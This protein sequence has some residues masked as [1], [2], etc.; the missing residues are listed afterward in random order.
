MK[1]Y[2]KFGDPILYS[3][4]NIHLYLFSGKPIGYIHDNKIYNY[5]GKHLGWL[6]MGWLIDLHGYYSYF[7]ENASGGPI[8]PIKKIT[9]I[10]GIKQ[11]KPIK[12]IREISK[13][14][15]IVQNFWSQF[16]I[17]NN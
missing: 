2:N 1:F 5:I 14:R 15:P 17:F 8:K 16:E 3:E 9:P 11:I 4:D 10:K 7:S 6:Y 12:S 13:I